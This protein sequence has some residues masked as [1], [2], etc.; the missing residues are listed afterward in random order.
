[1]TIHTIGHSTRSAEEVASLL[2]A[3]GIRRVVDVRTYPYSQRFPHF[4]GLQMWWWLREEGIDYTHVPLLGGRRTTGLGDAS[5]NGAWR[6]LSFRN[7]ADWMQGEWFER[8]MQVLAALAQEP[9]A[10]MCSEAVPWRCHRGLIADACLARGWEVRHIIGP[11]P[12]KA[13]K[14]TPFARF[15]GPRVTYPDL[16]ASAAAGPG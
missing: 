6:N 11:E 14:Q 8:G 9:A 15:D 13:H 10:I 16:L 3:S 12:P 5:P 2:R 4:N 1:M 7:F